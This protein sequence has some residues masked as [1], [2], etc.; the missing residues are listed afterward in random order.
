M[1]YE[2]LQPLGLTFIV[3]ICE[4]ERLEI[5]VFH[6][7]NTSI[8]SVYQPGTSRTLNISP[9]KKSLDTP[10]S[11]SRIRAL[12]QFRGQYQSAGSIG[13]YPKSELRKAGNWSVMINGQ[14]ISYLPY[15]TRYKEHTS[16]S[17]NDTLFPLMQDARWLNLHILMASYSY[18]NVVF[19]K[20][21]RI[22]EKRY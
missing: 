18:D 19:G 15:A 11:M 9:G 3:D 20:V 21:H 4:V 10:E 8:Y 6:T 14:I 12:K 17:Q 22:T 5:F 13:P 1:K 7:S 2:Y 16:Y